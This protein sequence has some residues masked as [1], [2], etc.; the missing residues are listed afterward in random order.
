MVFLLNSIMQSSQYRIGDH[1]SLA[2]KWEKK[3][4]VFMYAGMS[5]FIYLDK[6]IINF[7]L[8]IFSSFERWIY[9]CFLKLVI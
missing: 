7:L 4:L 1:F 5:F 2:T 9:F 3:K 8:S 6:Y